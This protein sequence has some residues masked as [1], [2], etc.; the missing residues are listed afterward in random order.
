[1]LPRLEYEK[2]VERERRTRCVH[3]SLGARIRAPRWT[4]LHEFDRLL[5][6]GARTAR[7]W[8]LKEFF[9]RSR[10]GGNRIQQFVFERWYWCVIV[11][12]KF[13]VAAAEH[14]DDLVDVIRPGIAEIIGLGG[15]VD[16]FRKLRNAFYQNQILGVW[17][18]VYHWEN[19]TQMNIRFRYVA[20]MGFLQKIP[21]PRINFC[22]L[23]I[24]S[25]GI[26]SAKR[27]FHSFVISKNFC[28]N[29]ETCS[30]FFS[31]QDLYS[32]LTI[33]CNASK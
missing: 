8:E 10:H 11:V 2:N 24:R 17:D 6:R 33:P 7:G 4:R 18:P 31:E 16:V 29:L 23:K 20:E 30:S 5:D 25:T 13:F 27:L 9:F 1:M 32:W 19:L 14:P 21:N 28:S 26:R 3:A 12:F 22:I 15:L